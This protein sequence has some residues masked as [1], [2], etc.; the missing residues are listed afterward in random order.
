MIW[1]TG[2]ALVL[3]LAM[4]IGLILLVVCQGAST[5]WPVTV[6]QVETSQGKVFLG[7]VVRQDFFKPTRQNLADDLPAAELDAAEKALNDAGGIA[8]RR[9]IHTTKFAGELN[10]NHW[11]SDFAVQ[12]ESSPAW[13]VLFERIE[14]GRLYGEPH[15]FVL[16]G[17]ETKTAGP[18]EAWEFFQEHHAATRKLWQ[19]R[20]SLESHTLGKI[21]ARL[22]AARLQERKLALRFGETS[23]EVAAEKVRNEEV[24]KQCDE[25]SRVVLEQIQQLKDSNRKYQLLVR[26]SNERTVIVPLEEVVRGYRA[27]QVSTSE[28]LGIYCS[29]WWEFLSDEPRASNTE[30]GVLPAI[31]GTVVMTLIMSL[32]VAPFGV[33]AA[34]YLREYAKSGFIVSLIRIAINNLSGVPSIVFGVFGFGFFCCQVGA[35]IDGGPQ[36]AKFPVLPPATWYL[37]L[38]GLAVIAVVAFI[39]S[40]TGPSTRAGEKTTTQRWLGRLAVMLWLSSTGLLVFLI[41]SSPF[42]NG[43]FAASLPSPTFGTGG[44]LW[45]ALTLSLLTLPV[46][47]VSTEE[48][49]FAVPNSLRE[50][51][52]ACGAGKW[53][54]IRRIVLPHAMPGIMTGMILAM[55]RG[56][57]EVAPLMLVGAIKFAPKLPI[58]G[59]LP[60]I[61]PERSFMHLAFH[62]FDLGFQSPDSE[63]AKPTVY[64]TILLLIAIVAILN[65][66]AVWLRAR[67]RQAFQ[68]GQF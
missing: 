33:L 21:N 15:G 31:F 8:R 54:T 59:D 29:R 36:L 39:L 46:V 26:S 50:G 1:L 67:L 30:G 56:A 53:Q 6:V 37:S 3:S 47:I 13:I 45:S 27:N 18:A 34:L 12:A 28:K 40:I 35:F 63:A 2:G 19:Q 17:Q 68:H 4:I 16:D 38:L 22:E 7:E 55:S 41:A 48:A 44:I 61:H 58:D 32:A 49:L 65:I 66:A 5:F 23:A 20:R 62:I 60:F 10:S 24:K 11:V 43:F 57:G 51:S 52:Y 9:L 25:E 64:T 14:G 42:F